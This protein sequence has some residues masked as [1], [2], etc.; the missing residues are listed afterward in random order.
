M[1]S[2]SA[3]ASWAKNDTD[4]SALTPRQFRLAIDQGRLSRGTPETMHILGKMFLASFL[5][6]VAPPEFVAPV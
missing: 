6:G 1:L 3:A 4:L 2:G 5:S